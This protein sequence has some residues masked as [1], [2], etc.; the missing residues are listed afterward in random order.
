MVFASDM[1]IFK[2]FLVVMQLLAFSYILFFYMYI[3]KRENET[4]SVNLNVIKVKNRNM[5]NE[6]IIKWVAHTV[7]L[8]NATVILEGYFLWIF[9]V[10]IISCYIFV[11]HNMYF[12]NHI[13]R[14][15]GMKTYTCEVPY[16]TDASL[17]DTNTINTFVISHIPIK[18]TENT[19]Y[20]AYVVPGVVFIKR[21]V[22]SS[23]Y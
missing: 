7:M 11:D 8:I 13:L 12:L 19:L 10:I 22:N 6:P 4:N 2:T 17:S 21:E 1:Y 18:D 5:A 14:L 16:L 23:N 20:V 15:F 9:L 3:L